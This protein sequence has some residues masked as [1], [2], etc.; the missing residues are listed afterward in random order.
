VIPAAPRPTRYLQL[1][2]D[3]NG[4]HML[5][6]AFSPDSFRRGVGYVQTQAALLHAEEALR[7]L[8]VAALL[9]GVK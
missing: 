7:R 8:E 1:P 9:R 2:C 4:V 6:R 5:A 3:L